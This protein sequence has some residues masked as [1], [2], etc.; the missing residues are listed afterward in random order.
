ME[1][2]GE[3]IYLFHGKA[4]DGG[5]PEELLNFFLGKS[6]LVPGEVVEEAGF[7]PLGNALDMGSDPFFD[8]T[9]TW[10]PAPT[11]PT[12]RDPDRPVMCAFK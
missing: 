8:S 1:V 2:C 5:V 7:A 3:L 12:A 10:T 4:E 6:I 9:P 11:V